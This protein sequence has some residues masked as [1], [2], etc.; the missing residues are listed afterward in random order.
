MAVSIWWR[1]FRTFDFQASI[2]NLRPHELN[3][4]QKYEDTEFSVKVT[5]NFKGGSIDQMN[6]DIDIDSLQFTAPE[7]E[8]FMKTFM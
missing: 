1:K 2:K 4:T 8:Y 5:A 3:L 7:K 6:G